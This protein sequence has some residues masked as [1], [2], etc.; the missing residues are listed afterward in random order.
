MFTLPIEPLLIFIVVLVRVLFFFGFMPVWGEVFLPLRFRMLFST[1]VAFVF[2]PLLIQT[3]LM[4]VPQT[5]SGL[6]VLILPEALLGMAFGL[7]AR[8]VYA[9]FQFAGQIIG[10]QIGFGMAQMLDPSQTGQLPVLA[11]LMYLFGL[12]LFFS[13]NGHYVFFTA[14]AHSFEQAPP[15]FVG[16]SIGLN[17][18]FNARAADMFLCAVQLSMPIVAVVFV[19]NAALAMVAKAVPQINVFMESFPVRIFVGF[20]LLMSI[21]GLMARFML[22]MLDKMGKDLDGLLGI[23]KN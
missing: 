10:E 19:T 5:F 18:F 16:Y 9:T 23:M 3:H 1:A 20:L 2:T 17:D 7:V 14:L 6:L 8:L 11:Q 4:H 12:L 15:G 13:S 22:W 21:L